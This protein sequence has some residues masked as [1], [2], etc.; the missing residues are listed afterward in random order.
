MRK[1]LSF[2]QLALFVGLL[3]ILASLIIPN[4]IL[5]HIGITSTGGGLGT[6]IAEAADISP[7]TVNPIPTWTGAT[8]QNGWSVLTSDGSY[9]YASLDTE[10]AQVVKID[11]VTMTTVDTWAG[12]TGQ[13]YCEYIATDN[14][15][16]YA[17]LITE[18]G[19]V[20][21]IDSATMD[22]VDN[23]TAPVSN[24]CFAVFVDSTYIYV[25][26]D[27]SPLQV[28]KINSST[29]D[30]VDTWEGIGFSAA[31]LEEIVSGGGYI[32]T[33]IYS[34]PGEIVKIDPST[35]D[36]VD[37]WTG[38]S[39]YSYPT[40]MYLDGTYIY[41]SLGSSPGRVVK[42]ELST[43]DMVDS[44][45]ASAGHNICEGMSSDGTYLYASMTMS[46]GHVVK[47]NPTT[48]DQVD[49]WT[50]TTGLNYCGS[51]T[52]LN[53]YIY[54]GLST[55]PTKIV[56]VHYNLGAIGNS[57]Q[58][59]TFYGASRFWMF[60]SN[61][62]NLV[63]KSSLDGITWSSS[64][65]LVSGLTDSKNFSLWWDETYV[66]FVYGAGTANNDL[67]YHR[68]TPNVDGTI[69]LSA[70]Q[71]AVA[72]NASK[73]YLYPFISK[74]TSGYPVISYTCDNSTTTTPYAVK[75]NQSDGTWISDNFSTQL[76]TDNDT[77]WRTNILPVA[78]Q[79]L[80]AIYARDGQTI[81]SKIYDY[82]ASSFLSENVTAEDI[83]AGSYFSA[84][85]DSTNVAHLT[86]LED[87]FQKIQ[88]T[89]YHSGGTD[90]EAESTVYDGT[91][92]TMAP[93]LSKTL[94]DS[95]YCF[96]LGDS[97][98]NHVYYRYYD[99]N[100]WD[101][102]Q[103]WLT[104][105]SLVVD[106]QITC[107]Y[108]ETTT[109]YIPVVWL[110][111]SNPYNVRFVAL[112]PY[113]TTGDNLSI[114]N[115]PDNLTS[116]TWAY[117]NAG[118]SPVQYLRGNQWYSTETGITWGAL[119]FTLKNEGLQSADVFISSDNWTGTGKTW[120]L[121]GDAIP[122]AST[123]GLKAGIVYSTPGYFAIGFAPYPTQAIGWSDNG[124]VD[125]Q[126]H[127][128]YDFS[129]TG[130]YT[131]IVNRAGNALVE[132]LDPTDS[133]WWGFKILLPTSSVGNVV[134]TG[135]ITLTAVIH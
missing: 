75:S 128:G 36:T 135:I 48:M 19:Q 13:D 126:E 123:I 101:T 24:L 73:T 84:V 127:V 55:T 66:H 53:S 67:H 37:N 76:S 16:I 1:Y 96:W 7:V 134:M 27:A 115:S 2:K 108:E 35:M 131:I 69:T 46:P 15:Y 103:N 54:A 88:Y 124:D 60:Y 61:G 4:E 98:P 79:D 30:T 70:E 80:M 93:V 117:L 72:A 118:G 56:Q 110:T 114:I 102:V 100:I 23:W 3:F 57:N 43:M 6:G 122:L 18:P 64:T 99:D 17:S 45:I 14:V 112:E 74:D 8:G 9:I 32:Y 68:G 85:V 113:K 12:A 81:K 107:A 21:K 42:I 58:R 28:I 105:S 59:Q 65:T 10:P 33:S 121:A 111:G 41:S 92:A 104:E 133:V 26:V 97:L 94:G 5:T 77:N 62:T 87:D 50:G 51:L 130:D 34:N 129:G 83:E 82:S 91:S 90:W 11:S 119:K 44:W 39:G 109:N 47:L 63:F 78:S 71:N 95:L 116:G 132:G 120:Y 125:V 40:Q 89:H 49:M 31:G 38:D 52:Y 20:I 29:M 22:T 106:N 25:S 86:F